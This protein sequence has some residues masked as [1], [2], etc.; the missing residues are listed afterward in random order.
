MQLEPRPVTIYEFRVTKI[1]LPVVHFRVVCSTGTYIRSLSHD[2]GKALGVG[3][4]MSSLCRTR[5]GTFTLD[6]AQTMDEFEA[7]INRLKQSEG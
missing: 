6:Q 5:I 4:Y 7:E 3:G 2:F 1:E